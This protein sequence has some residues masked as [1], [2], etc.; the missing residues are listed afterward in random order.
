MFDKTLLH[1]SRWNSDRR[2]CQK[3]WCLLFDFQN[4]WKHLTLQ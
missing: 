2:L 1:C 4:L 3:L